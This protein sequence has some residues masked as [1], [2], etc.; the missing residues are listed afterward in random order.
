MRRLRRWYIP[1]SRTTSVQGPAPA[2]AGRPAPQA[3]AGP[4]AGA[5]GPAPASI[6][7]FM[8][9]AARCEPY[10]P[11]SRHWRRRLVQAL[12]QQ[13]MFHRKCTHYLS[14]K[15]LLHCDRRSHSSCIS[16][17]YF[18][19]FPPPTTFDQILIVEKFLIVNFFVTII[20]LINR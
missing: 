9:D 7:G 5:R 8:T 18:L 3:G 6:H 17:L 19:L 20:Q 4:W 12:Q 1:W 11:T 2:R 13:Y 15:I 14:T 10:R 16:Y